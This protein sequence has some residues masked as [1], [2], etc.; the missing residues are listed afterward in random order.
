MR[1]RLLAAV[2]LCAVVV[3]TVVLAGSALAGGRPL[4]A[5]LTG[6]AEVPGPADPDGSGTAH[7][8]LNQG[9]GTVCYRLTFTGLSTPTAAHIHAGPVGVAG[10]IVVP[11]PITQSTKGCVTGVS[12]SLVKAIRKH[13]SAYYV[14]I[15]TA[16]YP[17]G[18]I[19]GQLH[20]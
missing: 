14:N 15:H 9:R 8:T 7:L 2:S 11:L 19:R 4:D 13:P 5:T 18:A 16:E 10:P 12:R 20:K 3:A 1:I 6:A 17:A